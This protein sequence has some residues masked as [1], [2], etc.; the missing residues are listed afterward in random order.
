MTRRAVLLGAAFV[1]LVISV[2]LHDLWWSLDNHPYHRA[3]RPSHRQVA[4]LYLTGEGDDPAYGER[5]VV[6][7]TWNPFAKY[8][9][10]TLFEGYC[11]SPSN[12]H[13]RTADEL[14][15]ECTQF[16]EVR[17]RRDRGIG[18]TVDYAS[19][20]T[21]SG[22]ARRQCSSSNSR[23]Q[24]PAAGGAFTGPASIVLA[25]GAAAAEPPSRWAAG[26]ELLNSGD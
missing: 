4:V 21:A 2:W 6:L 14:V 22:D 1:G 24:R 12:L 13:W 25:S 9:P 16:T 15:L 11:E 5:L 18:F 8:F 7:P 23:L 10:D 3:P 17:R 19:P 20:P 26:D